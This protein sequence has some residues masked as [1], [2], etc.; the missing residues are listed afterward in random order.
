MKQILLEPIEPHICR[1]CGE[2]YSIY[3][4]EDRV[5]ADCEIGLTIG[6]WIFDK[7]TEGYS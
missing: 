4:N 2:D 6:Q 7:I 5:C 1:I 3:G